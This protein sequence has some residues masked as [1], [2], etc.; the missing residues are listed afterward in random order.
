LRDAGR[1]GTGEIVE[2]TGRSRPWV[3]GRLRQLEEAEMIERI[4]KGPTDP[5]AYWKLR[6]D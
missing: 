6:F 4:G 1:L 2:A 3:L 5:R